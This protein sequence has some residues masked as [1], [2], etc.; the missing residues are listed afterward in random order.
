MRVPLA[1]GEKEQSHYIPCAHYCFE[2]QELTRG[3][4][5]LSQLIQGKKQWISAT[6]LIMHLAKLLENKW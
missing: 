4:A 3:L 5:Q 1:H 2:P 6:P